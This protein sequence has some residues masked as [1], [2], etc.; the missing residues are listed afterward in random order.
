LDV[1]IELEATTWTLEPGHVLRLAIAGTDWP[2]CWPPPGAST[3]EVEAGSLEL[4]LPMVALPDSRHDLAPGSGPDPHEADGVEWTITHDVLPRE[5]SVST[6]YGDTY[7]GRHGATVTDEYR[8][9]LGVST[10]DPARAWARGR[11]AYSIEWPDA[12]VRTESTLDMRSDEHTFDVTIRL[13]VW[14]GED[15]IADR[16]WHVTHPR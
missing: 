12:C 16:S 14:D 9:E 15:E 4:V 1:V 7:D 3:L 10:C 11:S 5:T 8:G 2:N 6:R 13:R